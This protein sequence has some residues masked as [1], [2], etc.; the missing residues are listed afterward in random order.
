M[1]AE[2]EVVNE[3]QGLEGD[4]SFAGRP[5]SGIRGKGTGE[6]GQ[7]PNNRGV[8]IIDRRWCETVKNGSIKVML[9]D[10][11]RLIRMKT[12][13]PAGRAATE[14]PSGGGNVK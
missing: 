13:G 2:E 12:Q 7:A 4:N 1:E 11:I 14:A 8:R 5:M 6:G 3:T 10:R 9:S